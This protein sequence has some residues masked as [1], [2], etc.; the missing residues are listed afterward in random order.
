[1]NRHFAKDNIHVINK[2]EKGPHIISHHGSA[3]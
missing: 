3:S 2:Y 1:M